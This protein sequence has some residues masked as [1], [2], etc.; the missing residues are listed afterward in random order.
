MGRNRAFSWV[1]LAVLPLAIIFCGWYR[2][3][4]GLHFQDVFVRLGAS[5]SDR[6]CSVYGVVSAERLAQF[7][8]AAAINRLWV[9]PIVGGVRSLIVATPDDREAVDGSFDGEVKVG[10]AWP[11]AVGLP[12][13]EARWVTDADQEYGESLRRLGLR[14]GLLVRPQSTGESVWDVAA[15]KMNWDGDWNFV[16]VSVVQ[17]LL[18]WLVFSAIFWGLIRI[19][20]GRAAVPESAGCVGGWLSI[21]A[22]VLWLLLLVLTVHQCWVGIQSLLWVRSAS[23]FLGGVILFVLLLAVYV[24]WLRWVWVSQSRRAVILK[25]LVAGLLLMAAKLYWLRTVDYRPSSDYLL[26]HS[27][28]QQ[29]AGGDWEGISATPRRFALTYLQRAWC[30]SYPVCSVFGAEIETFEFVNVGFQ[31]LSLAVFC[32]LVSR[33]SGLTTAAACMPLV[34][35]YSEFWYSTGIVAPNVAAYFWIPLSWLLVD[36]F[37]RMLSGPAGSPEAGHC[38][39]LLAAVSLGVATGFCIAMVDLLKRYSPFFL[40]ALMLF[41]IFR[42]GL[43]RADVIP[44]FSARV[45]FLLVVVV[46]SLTLASAVSHK[47]STKSGLPRTDTNFALALL[48]HLETDSAALGRA[49]HHWIYGFYYNVPESRQRELQ[50]RKILHEQVAGGAN[51]Y[52]QVLLK[53]RVMAHPTNALVQILDTT[54]PAALGRM[55]MYVSQAALQVTLAWQ[56]SLLL[57]VAGILRLL[58]IRVCPLNPGE[59]FPL[60]SAFATLAAGYLLTEGHPYTGQNAAFPLIWTVGILVQTL[61]RPVVVAGVSVGIERR[62]LD[63]LTPRWL[64]TSAA[65]LCCLALVHVG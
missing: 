8:S 57:I 18:I 2:W 28:G 56:I 27:L 60:L 55:L 37:D 58:V 25:M 42:R 61:L 47:L 14:R 65:L 64:V 51:V 59:V 1:W 16:C 34:V 41:T 21:P 33:V 46:T 36:A 49:F 44:R 7:Q 12:I 26:F 54:S 39:S 30:Y 62:L 5:F 43:S 17:G 31:A 38:R 6:G 52:S 3:S 24:A 48:A 35:V 15:G 10:A 4:V 63:V 32:L 19:L 53:N 50:I 20:D 40:L 22:Q 13:C 45:L 29:L 9:F 11:D 23:G